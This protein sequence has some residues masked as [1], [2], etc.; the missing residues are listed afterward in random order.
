MNYWERLI[1]VLNLMSLEQRREVRYYV[2]MCKI[3]K[4]HTPNEA[5]TINRFLIWCPSRI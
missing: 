2:H 1:K 5:M 4:G 3:R